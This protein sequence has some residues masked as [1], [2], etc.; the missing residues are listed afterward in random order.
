MIKERLSIRIA[1][2]RLKKLRRIAKQKEKT[3]TQL[4]EDWI[5]TLKEEKPSSEGR[6]F[7][8]SSLVKYK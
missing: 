1:V 8:P 4:V 2:S 3:M 5:D 6:G 7:R